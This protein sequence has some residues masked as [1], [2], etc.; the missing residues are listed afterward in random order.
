MIE[1]FHTRD[2]VCPFKVR[3]ALAEK[4]I[5][6]ESRIVTDLRDP[7]YLRLNPK[8]VVPTLVHG[9]RVL[10]ESRIISEYLEQAFPSPP[11]MPPGPWESYRAR[12]WSKQIDDS[13]HLNIFVL[14][15]LARN[16]GG[17]KPA[18]EEE[19]QRRLPKDVLKRRI[20]L[21]VMQQG[22]ASQWVAIAI[23]RFRLLVADMEEG[24]RTN[25]WLASDTYSLADADLTAYF[26]R[27]DQIGLSTLWRERPHV[28]HWFDRVRA[29]PSYE[30]GI[31]AWLNEADAASYAINAAAMCDAVL[32]QSVRPLQAMAAAVTVAGRAPAP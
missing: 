8:G 16:F 15:F 4:G 24:L 14:T 3:I 31:S 1:L 12:L 7:H 21:E 22:A 13:L 32:E 10:T 28:A 20:A 11:L 19:R 17:L 9:D 5:A 30:R 6:W 18:T 2:A 25:G 27:L 23:D 26:H 29:R